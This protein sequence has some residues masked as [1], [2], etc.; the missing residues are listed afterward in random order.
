MIYGQ[1]SKKPKKDGTKLQVQMWSDQ[2]ADYTKDL[3]REAQTS[4]Q[5]KKFT[6]RKALNEFK[7]PRSTFQD[8]LRMLGNEVPNVNLGSKIGQK[9]ALSKNEEKIV[10]RYSDDVCEMGV[11]NENN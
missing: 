10:G 8:Y 11:S 4:I 1:T 5:G 2:K 7:I 6:I 9:I 3:L